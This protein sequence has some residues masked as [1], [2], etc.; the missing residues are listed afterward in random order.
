MLHFV[1]RGNIVPLLPCFHR[2]IRTTSTLILLSEHVF[3][4][5][6][7]LHDVCTEHV[8]HGCDG[9]WVTSYYYRFSFLFLPT[10]CSDCSIALGH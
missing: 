9:L 2:S 5:I 4:L 8:S 7:G 3:A 6:V 10:S 1:H